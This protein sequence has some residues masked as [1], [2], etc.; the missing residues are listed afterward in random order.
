[1]T[2]SS[3]VRKAGPFV[4]N[5]STTV[6]PFTFKVFTAADLYVVRT[7]ASLALDVTLTMGTDY[8]VSLNADQNANPGGTVTLPVALAAGYKL[9]ITSSLPYTQAT[10][11]TNQGGFYPAV[12]T[13]ALDRLTIL[14]QQLLEQVSRC[15]KVS[16]STSADIDTT[17]PP[18]VPNALIGW[19]NNADGLQNIDA[20]GLATIVAFGT[21]YADVFVGDGVWTQ[22]SLTYNPGSLY[23][24]DVS[25]AGQ[26]QEPTAD[27]TWLS[28]T[29]ITFTSPPP[30]G[31]RVLVRYMQGLPSGIIA[32]GSVYA[33]KLTNDV[34]LLDAI[35][36]KLKYLASG[37]GA[38]YR[39]LRD[40]LRERP[41]TPQD[42]GAV[43]DGSADDTAALAAMFAT[44]KPWE[45]PYTTGGYKTSAPLTINANGVC[46]GLISPTTAIG[47]LSHDYDRFAVIIA[48]AGYPIKRIIRGLKIQGNVTVRAA[49][50][51]GIRND[52][53]NS[54]L[55]NCDTPQ[56]NVGSVC[57]SYSVTY[58]KCNSWQC[59]KNFSAYARST[60]T[61]INAL[62]LDG[63]NYDTAVNQALNIGDTSWSDSMTAPNS[64]GVAINICGG[65]NWDGAESL[66]DNCAAVNI[67]GVYAETS[68]TNWL[69]KLGGAYDGSVRNVVIW[70]NFLKAAPYAVYCASAVESLQV[71]PNFVTG[72][73][74]SEV[75]LSSDI[76]GVRY[77]QGVAVGSFANGQ[78][79][80][81]A[82]R[83]VPIADVLFD[84]FSMSHESLVAGVQSSPAAL[85]KCY[86]SGEH[87]TGTTR[88]RNVSSG[89]C[90]YYTSPATAIAG[91]VAGNVFTFT[92]SSN[93]RLFNG[94]DRITTAPAGATY[95]RSVD[96][97]AGTMVVDGGVTPAGAATVSQEAAYL[98]GDT[99][100]F[101][102]APP[103]S[104]AFK[105]G[106]RCENGL[107]AVGSPK[108]WLCTTDGTPGVWASEGNL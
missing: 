17:L 93:A 71:G 60:S 30:S 37:T 64:H 90:V 103:T 39:S 85:T 46:H 28:G 32:D 9:T 99:V 31:A 107:A 91:T 5:D 72:I 57:R 43:G 62:T 55:I 82:F 101:T 15:L 24:L 42:F 20:G 92:V 36:A 76:Y 86:P 53:P 67:Y 83:S 21:A 44:G 52:C 100:T 69:L 73:T 38:V 4:G 75:R 14:C 22:Q 94:G 23:N 11:L 1:M 87:R 68:N 81:I 77:T 70:G 61:E 40:K 50:V 97:L 95:V 66:I 78:A 96:Y 49:G 13:N 74:C 48:D 8:S 45:I 19:N 104:G 34:S 102:G 51:N 56:L 7:Q 89:S 12:I 6:F 98:L 16:V 88:Y 3:Q 54:T 80:S 18:P 65:L 29:L 25:I 10:D 58:Y 35:V 84:K 33:D 47:A 41:V 59:N 106:S 26:T 63:G 108:R 105:R 79:V 27:F 2:I